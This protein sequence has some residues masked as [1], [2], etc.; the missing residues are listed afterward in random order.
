MADESGERRIV[1][2]KK[3]WCPIPFLTLRLAIDREGASLRA[4]V[5]GVSTPLVAWSR[6]DGLV[7]LCLGSLVALM[8]E[9]VECY[10]RTL[11]CVNGTGEVLP[12]KADEY[13][14]LL[15]L[16]GHPI[17]EIQRRQRYRLAR[18]GRQDV[19]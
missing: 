17:P 12:E 2:M 15:R 3:Y 5:P 18:D 13:H 9:Y 16:A 8:R 11:E 7:T 14:A 10:E 6:E 4:M 1:T 19:L